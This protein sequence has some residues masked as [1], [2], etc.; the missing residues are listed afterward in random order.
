MGISERII[1]EGKNF[2]R[3]LEDVPNS[4]N[5]PDHVKI[6]EF[7]S[8]KEQVKNVVQ[9]KSQTPEQKFAKLLAKQ[10]NP[11][12]DPNWNEEQLATADTDSLDKFRFM[13]VPDPRLS[14]GLA[15]YLRP[16]QEWLPETEEHI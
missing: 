15:R 10:L 11:F 6:E 1:S 9:F 14:P 13:E 12:L 5:Q 4:G 16:Q 7:L 2:E 3:E 8:V